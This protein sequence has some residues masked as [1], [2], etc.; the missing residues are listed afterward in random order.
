MGVTDEAVAPTLG[1]IASVQVLGHLGHQAL[2]KV[3]RWP[4]LPCSFALLGTWLSGV[5]ATLLAKA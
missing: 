4:R 2:E 1:V 5:L 3:I